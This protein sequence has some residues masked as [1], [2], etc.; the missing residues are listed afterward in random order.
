MLYIGQ[1]T[2]TPEAHLPPDYSGE[3]T[4]S[5]STSREEKTPRAHTSRRMPLAVNDACLAFHIGMAVPDSKQAGCQLIIGDLGRSWLILARG[6][7]NRTRHLGAI[8]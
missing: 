6:K 4:V 5:W 7:A 2:P 1:P 8:A 3:N